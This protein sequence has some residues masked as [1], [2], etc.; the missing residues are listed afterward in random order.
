ML[1]LAYIDNPSTFRYRYTAKRNVLNLAV[2]SPR[3]PLY[4]R[5][6][7]FILLAVSASPQKYESMVGT[8]ISSTHLFHVLLPIQKRREVLRKC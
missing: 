7:S 8:C 5:S 1:A 4:Y 6:E 2:R 3:A